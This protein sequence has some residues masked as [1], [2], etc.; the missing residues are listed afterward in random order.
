MSIIFVIVGGSD[1]PGLFGRASGLR[2]SGLH[3]SPISSNS[4]SEYLSS[5]SSRSSL[6]SPTLDN[7]NQIRSRLGLSTPLSERSTAYDRKTVF[8]TSSTSSTASGVTSS[9]E[10]PYFSDFTKWLS[11]NKT[12]SKRGTNDYDLKKDII[13]ENDVNGG[14]YSKSFASR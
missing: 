9:S 2:A 12:D 3:Q 4:R 1:H 10:T 7:L 11:S 8:G 13:K 6:S 5:I 14:Q